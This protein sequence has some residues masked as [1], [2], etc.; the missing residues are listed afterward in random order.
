M[1]YYGGQ[2]MTAPIPVYLIF[3]GSWNASTVTDIEH[4]V[5]VLGGS[6][7][8][9]LPPPQHTHTHKHKHTHYTSQP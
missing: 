8:R 9:V 2:L 6:D 3:Y 7:W 1:H 5:R 4:F